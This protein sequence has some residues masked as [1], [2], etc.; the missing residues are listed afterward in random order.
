MATYLLP[1]GV[2]I[3]PMPKPLDG[4]V[5]RKLQG[6]YP[7][8]AYRSVSSKFTASNAAGRGK[9]AKADVRSASNRE[10]RKHGLCLTLGKR[11]NQF[12]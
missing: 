12:A 9:Y 3:A 7:P 11:A 2:S 10:D 4:E 6:G 8:V 5:N 1:K